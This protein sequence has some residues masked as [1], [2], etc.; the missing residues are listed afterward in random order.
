MQREAVFNNGVALYESEYGLI[1]INYENN[2]VVALDIVAAKEFDKE[3]NSLINKSI[4]TNNK[5]VNGNLSKEL[6]YNEDG[7]NDL[8]KLVYKEILEY[9]AGERKRFDFPFELRGT[10]FQKKVWQELLKIPYGEVRS[11]KD[12]AIAIG[13]NKACRAVGGANNKNPLLIIVPCH[14]VVGSNG[15]LTGYAS[16]LD[17]KAKLLK[18]EKNK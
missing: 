9:F 13:N 12:I 3:N 7:Q 2:V 14:R 15:D 8:T 16:G 11:Y 5:E 1:K 10:S 17:L 6:S 18:L 4:L